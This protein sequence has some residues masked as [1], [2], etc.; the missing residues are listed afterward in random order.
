MDTSK[1]ESLARLLAA[2]ASGDERAFAGLYAETSGTLYAVALRILRRRDVA[3][4]VLQEAYLRVWQKAVQYDP[5]KGVPLAWMATVVRR[6]AIDRLRLRE[7][8][9]VDSDDGEIPI[10]WFDP[11]IPDIAGL[12]IRDCLERLDRRQ[13]EVLV[14]AYYFGLTH[15]E[16]SAYMDSPLGTVK[17]WVKRGLT[18]LKACVD[19]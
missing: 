6:C 17:S 11:V 18:Q 8:P 3:E 2:T 14:M 19:R 16:L 4:D 10:D 13:R 9:L 7:L 1:V 5:A 15:E 12:E